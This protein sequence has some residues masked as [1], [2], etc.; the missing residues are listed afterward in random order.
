L[1]AKLD[2]A[3]S[4]QNTPT[5]AGWTDSTTWNVVAP[6]RTT[7][8]PSATLKSVG[9]MISFVPPEFN[10]HKAVSRT[11]KKKAES[12]STGKGIDWATAEALAFGTLLMEGN[13]IRLSGQDV[14]RG[15]FSH[16]HAVL[17][18]QKTG[19]RYIPMSLVEKA[20]PSHAK[21]SVYNSSLSEFAVLGFELG[22]SMENPQSLV[23]W[24][25]QFGDFANGAQIMFDQFIAS[26]EEKWMRSNGLVCL[27][28]HGY[29]GQGPEHSSARLERFLQMSNS[30]PERRSPSDDP[31]AQIA[32]QNWQIANVS[33]PANYFHLLRRQVHRSFRKPLIVMSPKNL[34]RHPDCISDLVDFDDV[35]DDPQGTDLFFKR[36][37]GETGRIAA[38]EQVKRVV[39]CSGKVYYDLVALREKKAIKNVAIVRIEQLAPFPDIPVEHAANTYPN[40][41]IVW[42]Q[43]EPANMG[44][45]SFV[46]P[47]FRTIFA[48]S[49][50]SSFQLRYCGRLPAASPSTGYLAVHNAEQTQL[51]TDALTVA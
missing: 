24:E 10:I 19:E 45:F 5:A 18:D 33:T 46:A 2:L 6:P 42:C 39:F 30:N 29:D 36:V 21:F 51:C 7:G 35:P 13:H 26:G 25:A 9:E 17:H 1:E 4:Q 47:H 40:A 32:A 14:E 23:L 12:I 44:A 3:K 37:I 43:E 15:T 38:P 27:L 20:S 31:E 41:E 28:P 49:R 16:R 11:M 34:L 8:V 50:G 22:F 48:P